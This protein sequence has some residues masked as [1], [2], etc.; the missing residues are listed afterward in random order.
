MMTADDMQEVIRRAPELRDR[1]LALVK[2]LKRKK[3]TDLDQV[4]HAAHDAAFARMDCLQCANCC[5]TTSPLLLPK[6][7]EQLA[8]H[9]RMKPGAFEERYVRVDEDG[10]KVFRAAPCPFLGAD[11]HCSVYASRPKACREYPH[12]NRKKIHQILD[13]TLANALICPAVDAVLHQARKHY[14]GE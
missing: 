9:L 11:N 5:K 14:L 8:Q 1:N 6:D 13:L 12:T 7:I 10:D 2:R 3:P 4:F